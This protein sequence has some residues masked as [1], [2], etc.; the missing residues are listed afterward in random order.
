MVN[1]GTVLGTHQFRLG[2]MRPTSW[3]VSPAANTER[4]SCDLI[5]PGL[6]VNVVTSEDGF[7]RDYQNAPGWVSRMLISASKDP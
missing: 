1:Y 3:F 2:Q 4:N 7:H 5:H 6:P